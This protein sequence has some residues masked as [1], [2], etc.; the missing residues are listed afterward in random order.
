[1]KKVLFILL[2]F[3]CSATSF[4]Q[5]NK[6]D[7]AIVQAMFG[8]EKKALVEQ[9][10]TVADAK[11]DAFWKLYDEYED[12]RKELG[13]ERISI[14]EA[15]AKDYKSLDDK[16]ATTLTTNKFSWTERYT[17]FQQAY[18]TKF[19]AVVGALQAS[20]LMQLEDYLENNIRLF[21]QEQIPFIGELDKTKVNTPAQ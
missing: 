8:K 9:Y 7:V 6:E 5:S 1:M 20:R 13:R 4:A 15:Y 19:S 14:I 2:T 12:K 17:K 21:I 10:M 3:I 16:K 11:K 18:F